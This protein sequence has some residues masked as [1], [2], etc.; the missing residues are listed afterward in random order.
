MQT[1]QILLVDDDL[2][3]LQALPH[4]ISLRLSGV[5]IATAS[6]AQAA[7][8]LLQKQEYDAIVSDIKMPGMDGLALMATVY[9]RYPE[10]P[11]LLITGHGEHDLAIQALRGGAY[12]YIQKPIDRDDFVMTLQRALHTRQLQRQ[13]QEQQHALEQ[14]AL[15]L[16]RQVERR[17]HE[18]AAANA[19][20][21][22]YLSMT[23]REL[24]SLRSN[25][26]AVTQVFI[27]HF[28]QIDGVEQLHLEDMGRSIRRMERFSHELQDA[29]LIQ[30]DRLVLQ[31]GCCDLTAVCQQV[32]DEGRAEIGDAVICEFPDGRLEA[33]VDRAKISLALNHLLSN[34]RMYSPRAAPIIVTLRRAGEEAIIS[35]R[36]QGIGVPAQYLLRIYEP[37]YRV[38]GI[39][40]DSSAGLG[41]GLYIARA[42]VEQHGGHIDVQ[43]DS[44]QGSMFSIVL[45]LSQD[46]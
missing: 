25:W 34:A 12:D 28:Q 20:K 17:T 40:G 42:I 15:S 8:E 21:D 38:P 39:E 18:L 26:M 16:E 10:T 13:I 19:A 37:F 11:V 31:R 27:H 43:S 14:Y 3:L 46:V 6:S 33:V 35:V 1:G 29:S 23:T 44:G 36:D 4:T 22:R 7:L 30:M 5:E 24:T 9:E 41:L 32:L 45:P 2:A